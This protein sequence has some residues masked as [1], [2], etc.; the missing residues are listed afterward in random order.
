VNDKDYPEFIKAASD[1][2]GGRGLNDRQERVMGKWL[3]FPKASTDQ[4]LK[5]KAGWF[6]GR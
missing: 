6:N 1:Y 4:Y 3:G 5:R 2:M